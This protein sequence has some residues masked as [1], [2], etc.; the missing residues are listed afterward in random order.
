MNS[1][2]LKGSRQPTERNAGRSVSE[3]VTGAVDYTCNSPSHTAPSCARLMKSALSSLSP[4]QLKTSRDQELPSWRYCGDAS[5]RCESSTHATRD[6]GAQ[7]IA[8]RACIGTCTRAGAESPWRGTQRC[9]RTQRRRRMR[10]PRACSRTECDHPSRRAC[11][12]RPRAR[13]W[14]RG[15]T[16]AGQQARQARALLYPTGARRR[17]CASRRIEG[18]WRAPCPAWGRVQVPADR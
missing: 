11:A 12:R 16:S 13:A 14:R 7:D 18:T 1:L 4:T 8:W 3:L 5:A 2:Q 17:A 10:A 9:R 15:R 6:D